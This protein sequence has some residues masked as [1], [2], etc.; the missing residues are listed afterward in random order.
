[1]ADED[2]KGGGIKDFVKA[3]G[4]YGNQIVD[5][6]LTNFKAKDIE[7]VV[8]QMDVAASS[9][10]TQFGATR[11]RIVD[12]KS[13][14]GDAITSVTVLGGGF[15]DIQT[16]QTEIAETLNRNLIVTSES[17]DKLYATTKV[18]KIGAAE[19]V[20]SFK[21]AG[22]S[23]YDSTQEMQKVV[24][25]ARSVGVNASA[26]S[27]NV[28]TNIGEM[29]KFNF[30]GG[31]D[32]LAKMAAQAINM[33]INIR[34]IGA[35]IDKAFNPE[36]AIEMAA[37]LQRLGV[38]QSDLLDPLRLM[39]LAQNDPAELQNQISEMSKQFVQLNEKGQFEIMPGA[40][41]QMMEISKQLFGNTTELGKMALASAEVEDKM[42]KIKFPGDTFTED[43]RMMIANM[44]EMKGGEYKIRY[45]GKDR[46]LEEMMQMFKED[47]DKGGTLMEDFLKS[48]EPKTM[49][50]LAQDQLD[51]GKFTAKQVESIANR[52]G[53]AIGG[54]KV[55]DQA[56]KAQREI[57]SKVPE[58]FGGEKLQIKTMR[59]EGGKMAEDL[60]KSI[61]KGDLEGVLKVGGDMKNYVKDA[62]GETFDQTKKVFT[63]LGN[64]TNPFISI[65]SKGAGVLTNYVSKQEKLNGILDTEIK[66]GN[67]TSTVTKPNIEA[68][69]TTTD[70]KVTTAQNVVVTPLM[71]EENKTSEAL[72]NIEENKTTAQS[73]EIKN[74]NEGTLNIKIDAPANIDT[75]KL[76]ELFQSNP[77]IMKMIAIR[78]KE[79]MNNN[80]LTGQNTPYQQVGYTNP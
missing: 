64:S 13:A 28:V 51:T 68:G 58:M 52:M 23:A 8:K 4:K 1:M 67:E 63:D 42:K 39:D 43:Q 74:I 35:T 33:R 76:L 80:G 30:Q 46:N 38:A 37:S 10:V 57:Y 25:V 44:A 14:M 7:T 26:V 78:Y 32:G 12:I 70:T 72:K 16:I 29:N 56:S 53:A 17:Y 49:E 69:K 45:E 54:S 24:D 55:A 11:D 36:S 73:T 9:V 50:Q 60:M 61:S 79:T 27:K 47:K 31:V 19:L 2:D 20:S 77:D 48:Q 65:I 22:I 15:S 3:F 5:A 18:T 71:K 66:K 21:N 40:K 62:V 59:E 6:F 34:D 41:R 75:N